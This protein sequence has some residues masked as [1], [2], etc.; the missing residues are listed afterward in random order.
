MED[1]R[2]ILAILAEELLNEQHTVAICSQLK[3][4]L[5]HLLLV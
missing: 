2:Q 4:I 3:A 1:R 5:P